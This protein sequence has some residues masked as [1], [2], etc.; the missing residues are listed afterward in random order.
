MWLWS[1]WT[2]PSVHPGLSFPGASV[3]QRPYCL[4]VVC[5]LLIGL[6]SGMSAC[7]TSLASPTSPASMRQIRDFQPQLPPDVRGRVPP[8]SKWDRHTATVPVGEPARTVNLEWFSFQ[9]GNNR[10]LL[11]VVCDIPIATP[12]LELSIDIRN[13]P[14]NEGNPEAIIEGVDVSISWYWPPDRQAGISQFVVIANGS[15]IQY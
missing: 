12:D 13:A 3:V 4:L 9:D 11:L 10:Y 8:R 15:W 7:G 1:G 14:L 6:L 2:R 5:I